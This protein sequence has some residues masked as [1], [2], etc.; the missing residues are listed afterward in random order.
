MCH[1]QSTLPLNKKTPSNLT[2]K[3][4]QKLNLSTTLPNRKTQHNQ[5]H[6]HLA[7][8][9]WYG[10]HHHCSSSYDQPPQ[11]QVSNNHHI[12]TPT[13]SQSNA[14][15]GLYQG[16]LFSPN[17]FCH[18]NATCRNPAA[19]LL[20]NNYGAQHSL[21]QTQRASLYSPNFDG[22]SSMFHNESEQPTRHLR[23]TQ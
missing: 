1:P 11:H 9:A 16:L 5:Q 6:A 23:P 12:P 18:I 20:L 17:A 7:H 2:P 19:L 14:P 8:H 22:T 21:P 15:Q 4:C 10:L 3:F 13:T